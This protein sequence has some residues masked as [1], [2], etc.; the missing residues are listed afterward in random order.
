VIIVSSPMPGMDKSFV[1]TNLS[2]LLA[3]INKRVLIIDADIRNGRLHKTFSVEKQP[4]LSDLLAGK[5]TLDEVI[6]SLPDVG[7]D[8]IP[9]GNMVLTPSELLVL[10]NL[11]E[12]LEQ[13]KCFYNHI[14][15]DSAA[16][17]DSTDTAIMG[18]H[19]DATFLVVED[20]HYMAKELKASFKRFQQVG[21]KPNV[22]IIT[23]MKERSSYYPYYGYAYNPVDME[24]KNPS[25]L[26]AGCQ[27]VRDW[28]G[29][30]QDRNYLCAGESTL[31]ID[32][33]IQT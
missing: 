7:V 25:A 28:S 3:S 17:L 1:S 32:E 26:I 27:A 4:G 20:R 12:T 11:A 8:F 9:R 5:A 2:A 23:D 10:G 22:L 29:L 13:L 19:A 30:R 16:I 33:E 15:I 21:I 14:V 24:P 18:K 31:E 6:I